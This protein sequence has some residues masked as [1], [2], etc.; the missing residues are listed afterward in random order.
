MRCER[1]GHSR[2]SGACQTSTNGYANTPGSWAFATKPTLDGTFK[3]LL[4][5]EYRAGYKSPVTDG[6][7]GDENV[8]KKRSAHIALPLQ[9]RRHGRLQLAL[10]SSA[11]W[12]E[13]LLNSCLAAQ[14][15]HFYVRTMHNRWM[16]ACGIGVSEEPKICGFQNNSIFNLWRTSSRQHGSSWALSR[17]P[18]IRSRCSA[19]GE[20]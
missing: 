6:S 16:V 4:R 9:E 12:V 15:K 1:Y 5:A 11:H 13:Y 10:R 14:R 18:I 19:A 2:S 20:Y 3:H 8:S 7:T 17:S